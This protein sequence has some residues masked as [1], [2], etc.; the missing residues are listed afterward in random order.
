[1]LEEIA[2]DFRIFRLSYFARWAVVAGSISSYA[3]C[4]AMTPQAAEES[5]VT[6]NVVSYELP[7]PCARKPTHEDFLDSRMRRMRERKEEDGRKKD[8]A[9]RKH[10]CWRHQ[11]HFTCSDVQQKYLTR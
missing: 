11:D 1:M 8:E 4:A 2:G 9:F 7:D 3:G 5:T 6:G 10:I